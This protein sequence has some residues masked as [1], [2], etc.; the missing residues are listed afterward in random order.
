MSI[1]QEIVN[2]IGLHASE[3]S[4]IVILSKARELNLLI[5]RKDQI[6]SNIVRTDNV[7]KNF[8]TRK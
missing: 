1:H 6:L 8:R 3:Y 4:F 7:K 5:N 2:F